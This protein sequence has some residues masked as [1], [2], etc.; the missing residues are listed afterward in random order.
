MFCSQSFSVPSR[1]A[2]LGQRALE[3]LRKGLE[4]TDAL[5]VDLINE[6]LGHIENGMGWI[7]DG[8]PANENQAKIMQSTKIQPRS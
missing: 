3:T 7:I 2:E 5:I 1:R 4:M 6:S 8:F